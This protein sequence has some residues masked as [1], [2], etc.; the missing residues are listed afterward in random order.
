MA[1]RDQLRGDHYQ[2]RER[3]G[4]LPAF[5]ETARFSGEEPAGQ[6]YEQAQEALYSGPANDLSTYRLILDQAWHVTVIGDPPPMGLREQ[7][8]TILSTGE[9]ATLPDELLRTLQER[10][11]QAIRRGPWTERHVRPVPPKE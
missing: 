11:R 6:A 10:R 2:R 3:R 4:D 1:E 5:H 7:L 9:P 8:D